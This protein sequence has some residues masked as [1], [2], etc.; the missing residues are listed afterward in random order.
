MSVE[1]VELKISSSSIVRSDCI[2]FLLD[3]EGPYS[4]LER[5][6]S[7]GTSSWTLSSSGLNVLPVI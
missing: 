6:S 5:F 4:L 3:A 1:K 7:A 2:V